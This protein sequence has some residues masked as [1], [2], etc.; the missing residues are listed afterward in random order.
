MD[1]WYELS[2]LY[3]IF[4]ANV[5]FLRYYMG[6]KVLNKVFI[7]LAILLVIVAAAKLYVYRESE[8]KS[9]VNEVT[10]TD[11]K[12]MLYSKI[13]CRYCDLAKE[14]LEDRG[15][16]YEVIELTNKKD[17]LIKLASQTE[18]NTVPY[19]F[20]NDEFIG[21]YQSLRTLDADGKL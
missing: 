19:V 18:Q 16:P 15:I 17:L 9:V 6:N 8:G 20:V 10:R 13:G 5:I 1:L 7:A 11:I 21:G 14:L 3:A 4:D 2:L 12:V